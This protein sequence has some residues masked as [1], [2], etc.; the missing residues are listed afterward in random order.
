MK[1]LYLWLTLLL[2]VFAIAQTADFTYSP[3]GPGFCTPQRIIFSQA[4]T[5]TPVSYL[6]NF[7]NGEEGNAS[8]QLVTYT[9]PGTYTVQLTVIYERTSATVSKQITIN[10]TPTLDLTASKTILCKP[11]QITFNAGAN[12]SAGTYIW[13]FGDGSSPLTSSS[14]SQTFNYTTYGDF[15]V[16]VRLTTAE[17]CTKTDSLPVSIQKLVITGSAD[18]TK[19]CVPAT[20]LFGVQTGYPPGDALQSIVWNYGDGSPSVTNT[21][22]NSS[23]VYTTTSPITTAGVTITS[24]QGCTNN[25]LFDNMAF[26]NPP[27]AVTADT[28]SPRDTFCGSE[29]VEFYARA[30]GA[31]EFEWN[32]G[33]GV[34]ITVRDTVI[35][36]KFP[37][38]GAQTIVVTA[39]EN[40]CRGDTDTIRIFI[41]GVIAVMDFANTCS[42]KTMY[43]F[44]NNSLGV[45]SSFK[46]TFSDVPGSPDIT[47]FN[48]THRFPPTGS[49]NTT[50][51]VV[52]NNTGCRD[53]I[54]QPI[55][56]ARPI[57]TASKSAVCKDS[58][59]IYNV[60]NSYPAD[61]G[62]NYIFYATGTTNVVGNTT[63]FSHYP[64]VHGTFDDYVLIYDAYDGTCDDTLYLNDITVRGP[65]VDFTADNNNC[66]DTAVVLVNLTESFF[67]ADAIE[68]W[69]WDYGNTTYDSIR[70]PGSHLYPGP[71]NYMISLSAK[72]KN[73][74]SQT[75][76]KWITLR[77]VPV[78]NILPPI[79]TLCRGENT[80]LIAYSIDSVKWI[81]GTPIS[82]LNCDTV[83]VNPGTSTIYVVETINSFGCRSIDSSYIR[84]F[85]PFDVQITPAAS[86]ICPGTSVAL[87]LT[88]P[89]VP[90]WSPPTYLSNPNVTTPVSTP[91]QDIRYS[92]L[93][94]DSAGCFSDSAFATIT[95]YPRATADAGA[96]QVL[97]YSSPF[98]IS[99][100]YSSNIRE[101]IW[102]PAININCIDC[103]SPSGNALSTQTYQVD[104]T[105]GNG[106]KASDQVKIIVQCESSNLLLPNAFTPNKDGLNDYF[107][108]ITRGYKSIKKFV[109]FDRAGN[110]IFE[111]QG[112]PPNQRQLGWDG[113]IR[114]SHDANTQVFTWFV[115]GECETGEIVFTKGTVLLIR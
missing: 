97:P 15:L 58:L 62:Y 111:R 115:E 38:L 71:G 57:F 16:K 10:A 21:S 36:Y 110:K 105:D 69:L 67:P 93:V 4:A 73:G 27:P 66:Q 41:K 94:T 37:V 13:D 89:G 103:P 54:K 2:P 88:S 18:T 59:I 80:T 39:M 82:C 75:A 5:G 44:T 74:C 87:T 77:P 19:G 101:Y 43:S 51:L 85:T 114:S 7:G 83:M 9:Q 40:G 113:R 96:D 68:T 30:A 45:V 90:V 29:E 92:V 22:Y 46:W 100:I 31:N 28:R 34:K 6:W 8:T 91:E 112:I 56:T 53:S 107:Y 95:L 102:S 104:I 106:C 52:D 35:L 47:N 99:P 42:D 63:T 23:H 50:L 81:T 20:V 11:E 64:T 24:A 61:A 14:G 72:D 65:I 108:P 70:D 60:T 49:F 1:L 109:I 25:F 55:Y 98:V 86:V 32:F 17:G 48:T 76:S 84:V 12:P 26:G 78:V 79:D 33:N 3:A